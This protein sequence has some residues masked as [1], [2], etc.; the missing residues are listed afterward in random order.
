MPVG[1]T[2]GEHIL[3]IVKGIKADV[4]AIKTKLGDDAME[5]VDRRLKRLETKI[6]AMADGTFGKQGDGLEDKL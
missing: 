6:H 2:V 1:K 4:D 3:D 5:P